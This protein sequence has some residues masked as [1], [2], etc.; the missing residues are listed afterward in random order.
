[1][2]VNLNERLHSNVVQPET[3]VHSLTWSPLYFSI[4]VF[5]IESQ[6]GLTRMGPTRFEVAQPVINLYILIFQS[7]E[8]G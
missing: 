7:L 2:Y 8:I 1:M 5:L 4:E 3:D 6:M